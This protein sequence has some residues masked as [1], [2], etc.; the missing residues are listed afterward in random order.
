MVD[1]VFKIL[2]TIFAIMIVTP[3]IVFA[4]VA[5][6]ET[7]RDPSAP[8][9]PLRNHGAPTRLLVVLGSGGHTAEMLA[10]LRDLDTSKYQHRSY[11]VSAGDAFSA[12]RAKDF[13]EAMEREAESYAREN[14]KAKIAVYG[15]YD[16]AVVPRARRVHQSLVST[17]WSCLQCLWACFGVMD[18]KKF[19]YPDLVISNGPGTG[20]M[21]VVASVMLRFVTYVPFMK[22]PR[23]VRRKRKLR[24]IYVESWA[25]V[26]KLSLS[27]KILNDLSLVDR[28]IVQWDG[29]RAA[30][31]GKGEYLGVLV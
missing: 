9:I 12:Q 11:V 28:F 26:K 1:L 15:T 10:L 30:T 22:E 6:M 24:T 4:V 18:N 25:R 23:V 29:L 19:G 7:G 14:R 17:P 5:N 31:A 21:V 8:R 20:V 3:L 2:I 16:V 27:G 13:E